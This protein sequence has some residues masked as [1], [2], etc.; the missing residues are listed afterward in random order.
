MNQ[1][2][3]AS[4]DVTEEGVRRLLVSAA[5]P[6]P[7]VPADVGARLD[8]VL[9]DLVAARAEGEA[10]V[11]APV[12]LDSSRRRWPQVLVAAAAV[13]VLGLGI[14]TVVREGGMMT[15]QEDAASA[16]SGTESADRPESLS[17]KGAGAPE[18]TDEDAQHSNGLNR[19][20]VLRLRSTSLA[21]DLQRVEDFALAVPAG[22]RW[23]AA[24]VR[25][26]TTEGDEWL[27]V[28]LDGE[29][30]VLLLREPSG[31]RRRADVYTCD[32]EDEPAATGTVDTR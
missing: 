10:P 8:G 22:A 24:C 25:P 7:T 5:G 15:A 23:S 6:E 2:D 19:T 20:A 28:R 17:E 16:G 30:A 3:G 13:S 18:T 4:E 14:G 21:L 26:A 32:D 9:A 12:S 11:S 1:E 31:D 27:P 29:P